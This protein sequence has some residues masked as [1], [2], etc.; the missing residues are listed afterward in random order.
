MKASVTIPYTDRL[1]GAV[2]FSGE[3]V[4]LSAERFAELL[5]GGFVSALKAAEADSKAVEA[6]P[7]AAAPEP[8]E[9][10]AETVSGP[11]E[12]DLETMTK[13]QLKKL[14]AER[15][16]KVAAK[17]TNADIVAAIKAAV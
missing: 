3:A 6:K 11:Q 12:G 7:A 9:K 8:A 5:Q 14:A 10:A 15:G 4:E 17:A 2:H 1:T 13:A 16:V